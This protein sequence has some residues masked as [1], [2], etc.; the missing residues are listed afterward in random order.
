MKRRYWIIGLLVGVLALGLLVERK[1]S[2]SLAKKGCNL[3][4]KNL[5]PVEAKTRRK[6]QVR[7][8]AIGDT[9]T[10]HPDAKKIAGAIK[11]VCEG[12]GCDFVLLL[13]DN[14]Y[15]NGLK[16]EQDPLFEKAFTDIYA[17]LNLPFFAVLGNHDVKGKTLVQVRKGLTHPKWRMAN[18]AYAFQAG[19]ARFFAINTNCSLFS[20]TGLNAGLARP[21][22]GWTLVFGHHSLFSNGPHGDTAGLVRLYWDWFLGDKVDF[23]LSGHNHGLEHLNRPGHGTEFIVSG[24]GGGDYQWAGRKAPG[25]QAAPETSAAHSFFRYQGGGFAHL[26]VAADQVRVGYYDSAGQQIYAFTRTK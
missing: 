19:P 16:S 13:G 17:G 25:A 4:P 5:Y 20:W 1:A 6:E 10:A 24:A 7:F 18:Y 21:F 3:L 15:P 11:R 23:Y 22:A 8:I 26:E 12:E 9:G 2:E 14:F